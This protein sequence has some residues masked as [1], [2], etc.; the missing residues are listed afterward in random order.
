[1]IKTSMKK[2]LWIVVASKARARIFSAGTRKSMPLT[3]VYVLVDPGSRLHE[4]AVMAD[5]PGRAHARSGQGRHAMEQYSVKHDG[6]KRFAARVC[7]YLESAR[8]Q[9]RFQSLMLVASPEFAGL[10][11][12][13]MSP[14]LR[15]CIDGEIH[16]N[17]STLPEQAIR[18]FLPSRPARSEQKLFLS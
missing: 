2:T 18:E 6:A 7:A 3:E 11:H 5:R 9:N 16:K 10:L 13:R 14:Q 12:G 1:M 8:R 17:I 15:L 4:R